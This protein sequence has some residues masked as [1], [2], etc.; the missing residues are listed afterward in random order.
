MA[1]AAHRTEN[2]MKASILVIRP[3]GIGLVLVRGTSRSIEASTI[4]LWRLSVYIYMCIWLRKGFQ[5]EGSYLRVQKLPCKS[6]IES[7]VAATV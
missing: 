7:Q 6:V 3:E 1:V 2:D 5:S 4:S